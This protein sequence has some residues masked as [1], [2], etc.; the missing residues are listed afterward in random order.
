MIYVRC[1]NHWGIECE[2]H[3]L[4]QERLRKVLTHSVHVCGQGGDLDFSVVPGVLNFGFPQISSQPWGIVVW[5]GWYSGRLALPQK[6]RYSSGRNEGRWVFWHAGQRHEPLGISVSELTAP[7]FRGFDDNAQSVMQRRWKM[8][9]HES[10][11]QTGS[12][13]ITVPKQIRHE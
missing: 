1:C 5:P 6:Q 12:L 9:K 7:A 8:W 13:A 2:Q 3:Q 4:V 10:Q 11:D